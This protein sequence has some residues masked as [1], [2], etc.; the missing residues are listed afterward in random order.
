MTK[1]DC[2]HIE[3]IINQGCPSYLDFEEERD[4]KYLVL[5][6][7]NQHTFD[8]HPKVTAKTMNNEE[9]NSHI[10]PYKLWVVYF[11]PHC[12]ATPQGIREKNGKF[13]VIF[14]SLM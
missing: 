3:H 7:G 2:D 4:N 8:Q 1:R 11:S 13:R 14:D 5:C 6:K 12:Q 9:K 10:L